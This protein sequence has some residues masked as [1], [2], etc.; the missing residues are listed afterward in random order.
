[1]VVVATLVAAPRAPSAQDSSAAAPDSSHPRP[2]GHFHIGL[3]VH[4]Y[5]ISFGNA[6]CVTGISVNVQDADLE[7]VNGVNVMLWKPRD[8]SCMA[9]RSA[10]ST[11]PK[12]NKGPFKILPILNIHL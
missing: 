8:P 2:S 7:R 11:G 4:D 12:N 3:T 6:P 1:M 5:G 10:Y 9:F